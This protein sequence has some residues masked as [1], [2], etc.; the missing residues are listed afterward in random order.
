MLYFLYQCVVMFLKQK[1]DLPIAQSHDRALAET[2]VLDQSPDIYLP[3]DGILGLIYSILFPVH[4]SYKHKNEL[5][6][7]IWNYM[8]Q[9]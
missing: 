4:Q 7:K 6:L 3:L 8:N 1:R 9:F 2:P 5:F